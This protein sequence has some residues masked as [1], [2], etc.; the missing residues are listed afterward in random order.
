[1]CILTLDLKVIGQEFYK[2]RDFQLIFQKHY[3]TPH[4]RIEKI[5]QNRQ[6]N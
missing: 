1:M 4:K 3:L 5:L 6:N 2:G